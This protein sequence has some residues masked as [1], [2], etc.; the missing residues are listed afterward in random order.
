MSHI[1]A[2][3][4]NINYRVAGRGEPLMMIMG[5]GA[6]RGGW[7]AQEPFFKKY[8]RVVTFDN[9]GVGG[10]DKPEGPYSTRLL[11]ADTIGLM[12]ALGINKAN[13]LG[14]SMGGMIAQ[15]L[16]INYPERVARLVLACTFCCKEGESGDT[17]QQTLT[18]GLTPNQMANAMVDLSLNRPFYRLTFGFLARIGRLF[19]KPEDLIGLKGQLDACNN[20]NTLDRLPLIKAPTLVMAGTADHIIKPTSS[21]VL[22]RSI[23]NARLIKVEGGSHMF[24]MEARKTFNAEVLRFLQTPLEK[25]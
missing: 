7:M 16:A 10:S 25:M 14:A 20:H 15:E 11:A 22:A 24:F 3:G 6:S 5:F 23:P 9:R 13:I 17:F 19:A 4:I 8:F 18:L 1:R 21:D 12:D 2:N